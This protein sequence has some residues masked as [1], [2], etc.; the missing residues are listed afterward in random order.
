MKDI[1]MNVLS[2]STGAVVPEA[3]PDIIAAHPTAWL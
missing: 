1:G 3:S 2:R